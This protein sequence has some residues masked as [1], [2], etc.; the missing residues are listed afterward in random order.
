MKKQGIKILI[1]ALIAISMANCCRKENDTAKLGLKA[2][3][4]FFSLLSEKQ[5]RNAA[6][7]AMFD[8]TGT[9]MRENGLPVQGI[10]A[11]KTVLAAK[12]DTSFTL[13]WEPMF[14]DSSGKLGYTYGTWKVT[15]RRT[16]EFIGEGTYATIWKRNGKGEW[17]AVLD[18]G[19][20][21]LKEN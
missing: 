5:G 10:D 9:M 17:K 4:S 11:I 18:V 20:D 12:P 16:G 19:N 21:G 7:L 13:T 2:T 1:I 15:T 6:F 8:S 14:A 3:D